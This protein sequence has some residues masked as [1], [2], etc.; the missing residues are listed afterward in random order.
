MQVKHSSLIIAATLAAMAGHSSAETIDRVVVRMKPSVMMRSMSENDIAQTIQSA[1]AG[2]GKHAF[3]MGDGQSHVIQLPT[4]LSGAELKAYIQKLQASGEFE[5]V[6]ADVQMYPMGVAQ[7]NDSLWS[8]LWG[9]QAPLPGSTYG[10][11]YIGAWEFST[12]QGVVVGIVDTGAVP[13]PDLGTLS[14]A[15]G[16]FV[17]PGYTFITDCYRA[18]SC[19]WTSSSRTIAPFAGALDQGDWCT[20]TDVTNGVCQRTGTSSFHGS[21]VAGTIAALGYNGVGV[22]GGAYN[23]KILP[24]R[25]LGKGGGS[26]IDIADAIRWA[27]GIHPSIPN[28]N[29]AKVI[30]MSLGG[31]S[32]TCPSFY[33]SAINDATN[34]GAIVVVAGGN[35]NRDASLATPANCANVITVAATGKAGEKASYSNFGSKI[36]LAAPGGNGS[37][38]ITSTVNL[39][40]SRVDLTPAGFGYVGM[41]GTSMATPHVAAAVALMLSANP[42]LKYNDVVSLLRQSATAFPATGGCTTSNCGAGILNAA[43]AVRLAK[44]SA[45]DNTEPVVTPKPTTP[46]VVTPAPTTPPVVTPKPTV[47][48][49]VTPAPT[50]VA[51]CYTAW[52]EGGTFAA[53][54]MVTFDGRNYRA[55]V[56]HVAYKGANWN[57]KASL[58]LWQDIGACTGGSTTPAPTPAPVVTPKPS[59]A[60]VVTPAPSTAPTNPSCPAWSASVAYTGGKCVSFNGQTYT[61]KW[62]T[63]GEQPGA[64][65]WGPWL[66]STAAAKRK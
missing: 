16:N 40:T 14:P 3:T 41:N 30:N 27:A 15:G 18:G 59:T 7:P 39:S 36:T 66:A 43:A 17:S 35:E 23:A 8:S 56:T 9:F 22:I 5:A 46:P 53:G 49:V 37:T 48:P 24:V 38:R 1:S 45:G 12:G 29:P 57:P 44:Q 34:A 47:P 33:Q 51:G 63:M 25:A 65:Q 2:K 55:R 28:P 11:D 6:E 64:T 42:K 13:H 54:D 31:S 26:A 20:S 10:A 19:D 60:P 50:P 52:T 4:G 61:A 58:N 32:N 21:H 62:W